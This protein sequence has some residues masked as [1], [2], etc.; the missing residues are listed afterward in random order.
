[1]IVASEFKNAF[2]GSYREQ[3]A[4]CSD[5]QWEEIWTKHWNGFMLWQRTEMWRPPIPDGKSVLA[6]TA[7]KLRLGYNN[8]EP[9]KLDAVFC[10]ASNHHPWF[11][12]VVAIEHE[13]DARGFET[14]IT[15]LLSVRCPLKVGITYTGNTEY[16]VESMKSK[17]R[18]M[19]EDRLSEVSGV[20]AEDPGT[21]YL[22]LAGTDG[23]HGEKYECHWFGLQFSSAEGLRSS[24]FEDLC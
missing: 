20:L 11:P 5:Q 9:L 24:K 19:I 10:P 2:V 21:E 4:K 3:R 14:E 12:I 6:L 17:I 16:R 7:E 18:Q 15:K 22:F 13:N 1:M 23:W 8:G